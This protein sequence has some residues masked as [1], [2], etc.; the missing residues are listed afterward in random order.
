MMFVKSKTTDYQTLRAGDRGFHFTQG[1]AI[2][3]RAG[4]IANPECPRGFLAQ[5][6]QA[7]ARGWIQPVANMTPEEYSWHLLKQ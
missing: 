2:V 3:P 6:E 5:L 7:L 4:I 1:V